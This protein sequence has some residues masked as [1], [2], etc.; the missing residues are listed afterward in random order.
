MNAGGRIDE[1]LAERIR[2]IKLIAFDFDGVFTD[3]TVWVFDDGSEAVRGSRADG[4]GLRKLDRLHVSTVVISSETHPIVAIRAEK[5]RVRCMQ[6]C[7]EKRPVLE[8]LAGEA[9]VSLDEVAFVG[10]DAN[11]R[12]CLLAVGLPIVVADA[13]AD[14][15]ALGRYRTRAPGGHGA[16]REV[17]D[18]F[19][20]VRAAPGR[21]ASELE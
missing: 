16:V 3:N 17:C 11:D 8:R 5:L 10:N 6:S 2:A 1:G 7:R 19:E 12:D 18:L 20:A 9:R 15:R 21:A 13:H 4:I 14:V